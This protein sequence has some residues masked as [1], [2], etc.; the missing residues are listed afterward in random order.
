MA[1]ALGFMEWVRYAENDFEYAKLG[2]DLFPPPAAAH[3]QQAAEKYLKAVLVQRGLTPDRTHNVVGLAL[4][5]MPEIDR[6]SLEIRA[7]QW[8]DVTFMPSKYPDE[9]LE[10]TTDEAKAALEA[11]RVIRAFARGKLG[12]DDPQ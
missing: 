2:L 10:I 12:L 8:L 9:L 5:V 1:D 3:C 4:L 11:A 6:S 7:A